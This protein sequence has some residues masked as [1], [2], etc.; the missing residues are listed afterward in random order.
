M[1]SFW[2]VCLP[3][4][5]DSKNSTPPQVPGAAPTRAS[6]AAEPGPH[7]RVAAQ[8]RAPG[9]P[10]KMAA[11]PPGHSAHTPLG[12]LAAWS[13]FPHG[14]RHTVM[15]YQDGSCVAW[16]VK[17][18]VPLT[19]LLVFCCSDVRGPNCCSLPGLQGGAGL[20][21]RGRAGVGGRAGLWGA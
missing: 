14:A 8:P 11:P 12:V 17:S 10:G 5:P 4:L 6:H 16:I 20:G 9:R 2:T 3:R 21:W 7:F 13:L 18:R 1:S 15:G 19:F